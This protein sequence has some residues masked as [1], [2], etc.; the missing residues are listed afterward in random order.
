MLQYGNANFRGDASSRLELGDLILIERGL[1]TSL[2]VFVV[3][4]AAAS[5]YFSMD[6]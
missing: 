6:E 3:K 4:Y 2:P 1:P 5:V